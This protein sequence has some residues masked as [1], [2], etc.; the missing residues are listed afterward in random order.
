MSESQSNNNLDG[1]TST[2]NKRNWIA[3]SYTSK[4][5]SPA[6]ASSV[7]SEWMP[8]DGEEEEIGESQP[9]K[10]EPKVD[11]QE[12]PCHTATCRTWVMISI[13]DGVGGMPWPS[14]TDIDQKPEIPFSQRPEGGIS[15][16]L[17]KLTPLSNRTLTFQGGKK[18]AES[19][20][21]PTSETPSPSFIFSTKWIIPIYRQT[22]A[23][24]AASTIA[25]T[26]QTITTSVRININYSVVDTSDNLKI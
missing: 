8:P 22:N 13:P 10:I 24:T 18:P 5:P 17:S 20:P 21:A 25:T 3:A 15:T 4:E 11:K 14:P 26:P 12:T 16:S 6:A 9:R 19:T 2:L 23:T 7:E 1:Y